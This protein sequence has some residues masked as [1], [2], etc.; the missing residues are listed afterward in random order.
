MYFNQIKHDLLHE[1]ASMFF[2]GKMIHDDDK[3]VHCQVDG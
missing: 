2:F 1:L 3:S